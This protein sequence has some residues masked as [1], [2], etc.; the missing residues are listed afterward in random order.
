MFNI[1]KATVKSILIRNNIKLRTTRTYKLSQE[2]RANIILDIKQ[3]LSRNTI[4]SKWNISK[5]YLS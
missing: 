5:S 1:D 3:G 4:I 2:D